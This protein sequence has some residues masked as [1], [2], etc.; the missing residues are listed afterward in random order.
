MQSKHPAVIPSRIPDTYFLTRGRTQ[1]HEIPSCHP[2]GGRSWSPRSGPWSAPPRPS[3][4]LTSHR[5]LVVFAEAVLGISL[6]Q[7]RLAH[8][9]V[10][11]H[12]HFEQVIAAAHGERGGRVRGGGKPGKW[13]VLTS[14][15]PDPLHTEVRHS[16]R[17]LLGLH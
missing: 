5:G 6:H 1:R 7:G 3:R 11:H 13:L 4:R 9:G 10:P 12:Q 8:R 2:P 15:A 17:R 16:V 14:E